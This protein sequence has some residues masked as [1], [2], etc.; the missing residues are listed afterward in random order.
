GGAFCVEH[1]AVTPAPAKSFAPL[2]FFAAAEA[3]GPAPAPTGA[4][5]NGVPVPITFW[6]P[7]SFRFGYPSER[8]AASLDGPNRRS[9]QIQPGWESDSIMATSLS[10]QSSSERRLSVIDQFCLATHQVSEM[11]A[12]H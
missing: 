1:G 7:C 8:F 4:R 11:K 12:R 10:A 3:T 6:Q 5:C 2:P 9:K